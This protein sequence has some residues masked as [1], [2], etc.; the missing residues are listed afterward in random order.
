MM[1]MFLNVVIYDLFLS[2]HVDQNATH[3]KEGEKVN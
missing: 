3:S 2:G 1:L